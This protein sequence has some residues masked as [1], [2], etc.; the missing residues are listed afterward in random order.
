MSKPKRSPLFTIFLTVFID[1]LGLSVIFPVLP[2]IFYAADSTFF[3]P[4]VSE[5]SISIYYGLML[6]SF[7]F[8][9][10]FGA[11]ILGSLSDR[12]G[13]KPILLISMAG[14]LIGYLLFAVALG[15]HSLL[16]LFLARMIPGFMGG[17][18]SIVQSAIA[19][20][21]EGKD[22]TKNFGLV[23]AAF[24]LG[25]IIGPAIG[26]WLA[27]ADKV[28]W[29]SHATPFYF[30]AILTAL[31]L[32]SIYFF[33][34]ETLKQKSKTK[35]HFTRGIDNFKKAFSTP[36]LRNTFF[37]VL[38]LSLGFTFF[39]QFFSVLLIEEFDY[40]ESDI[41]TLYGWIGI[42]LVLTQAVLV[43]YLF[44]SIEST[45]ILRVSIFFLGL[46]L[47]FLLIPDQPTWFYLINPMIAICQGVT[48][49]N[50]TTIVSRQARPDQ[51]GEI[52]GIN[53]SMNSIGQ[54]LPAVVISTLTIF[55][56]NLSH[57]APILIGGVCI[58]C[59][60]FLFLII[61]PGSKAVS[62]PEQSPEQV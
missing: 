50:M 46:S 52:L 56:P 14:A 41:G 36:N 61:R 4:E 16:L 48:S 20:I 39:T 62:T 60:W 59:A 53:Q 49:P 27:D 44:D 47:L 7:P 58:L 40:S 24:G 54:I 57:S 23:G 22:R 51:Q 9:Q 8:M 42:W 1:M 32:V 43:R 3:G 2:S 25:F 34:P 55:F 31:N 28:S 45:K 15:M 5:A 10:F 19:D 29:F 26:G 37:I 12:Y 11:P 30:T 6:A 33:F 13:R 17:N 18:I 21:S 38:L 35:I